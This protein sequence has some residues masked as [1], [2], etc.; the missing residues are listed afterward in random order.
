MSVETKVLN[1]VNY[2]TGSSGGWPSLSRAGIVGSVDYVIESGSDDIYFYELNTNV[3]NT[4]GLSDQ[5]SVYNDIANYAATQSFDTAYVYG[6]NLPRLS[7][8]GNKVVKNVE[9]HLSYNHSF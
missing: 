1:L 7:D 2:I 8:Q 4:G 3:L 6:V 9:T 5:Q